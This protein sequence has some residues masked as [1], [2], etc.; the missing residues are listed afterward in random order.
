M[1]VSG[2]GPKV[3][4][5]DEF[6]KADI[7]F[8]GGLLHAFEGHGPVAPQAGGFGGCPRAHDT[9][10]QCESGRAKCPKAHLGVEVVGSVHFRLR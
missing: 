6:D 4:Q 2:R 9:V 1:S 3:L 7:D 8:A 10:L 5:I